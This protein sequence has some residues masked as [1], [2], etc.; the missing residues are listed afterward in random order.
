MFQVLDAEDTVFETKEP[1]S[2][3]ENQTVL[4][5][6]TEPPDKDIV[7]EN[8]ECQLIADKL[9][10]NGSSQDQVEKDN[11]KT[12]GN[13]LSESIPSNKPDSSDSKAVTH[14]EKTKENLQRNVFDAF[15]VQAGQLSKKSVRSGT[16]RV[17]HVV[18]KCSKIK[19]VNSM[20]TNLSP[21]RNQESKN[22]NFLSSF[23]SFLKAQNSSET[24]S[25]SALKEHSPDESKKDAHMIQKPRQIDKKDKIQHKSQSAC[26][27]ENVKK[28]FPKLKELRVSLDSKEVIKHANNALKTNQE[29]LASLKSADK[30]SYVKM[31][32][33]SEKVSTNILPPTNDNVANL[34][35]LAEDSGN[36]KLKSWSK[37]ENLN[38]SKDNTILEAP[39]NAIKNSVV[40]TPVSPYIFDNDS[41]KPLKKRGRRGKRF[42]SFDRVN[43][44]E[45][46]KTEESNLA[47]KTSDAENQ[48][49]KIF[50]SVDIG[51]VKGVVQEV[52]KIDSGTSCSLPTSDLTCTESLQSDSQSS[53]ID[54][55]N[56]IS[57]KLFA[58]KRKG[59]KGKRRKP[60]DVQDSN[61]KQTETNATCQNTD[62]N[63]KEAENKTELATGTCKDV[64]QANKE[65]RSFSKKKSDNL[66]GLKKYPERSCKIHKVVEDERKQRKSVLASSTKTVKKIQNV[67]NLS[68]ASPNHVE[69]LVN[70]SSDVIKPKK[71][72]K[73]KVKPWSWG[74]EKKKYKPKPKVLPIV[75]ALE[76]ISNSDIETN[77]KSGS[78]I[79]AKENTPS[80]SS[81]EVLEM[82]NQNLI[83]AETSDMQEETS[84]SSYSESLGKSVTLTVDI[85]KLSDTCDNTTDLVGQCSLA[86]EENLENDQTNI[87]LI[88]K[89]GHRKQSKHA[90]KN[91]VTMIMKDA[92]IGTKTP[93]YTEECAIKASDDKKDVET[94]INDINYTVDVAN[95]KG[96]DYLQ[97]ETSELVEQEKIECEKEQNL[98]N[99]RKDLGNL[100]DINKSLQNEKESVVKYSLESQ[101]SL[102]VETEK[103]TSEPKSETVTELVKKTAKRGKRVKRGRKG[104]CKGKKAQ[105]VKNTPDL[106]SQCVS[107]QKSSDELV[108][109]LPY[110]TKFPV[111]QDASDS[112]KIVLLSNN[113]VQDLDV[114]QRQLIHNVDQE[115]RIDVAH[116]SPDSGIESVAGSPVGNE[117]PS[118]VLSSEPPS[119]ISYHPI[120]NPS[121]SCSLD[122]EN[123]DNMDNISGLPSSE[124]SA[125]SD[126][127]TKVD[128]VVSPADITVAN[129]N[130]KWSTASI[131][132]ITVTLSA[133]GVQNKFGLKR[134][135][136]EDSN[137]IPMLDKNKQIESNKLKDSLKLKEPT[138][139]SV[140]PS[141]KKNRTNFLLK[142]KTS[143]L[144]QQGRMP[145]EEEKEH[146]L[147][148]KFS[149]LSKI[150]YEK[151]CDNRT[152]MENV[153]ESKVGMNEAEINPDNETCN[154]PELSANNHAEPSTCDSIPFVEQ[155]IES[156]KCAPEMESVKCNLSDCFTKS[157]KTISKSSE[158]LTCL[159]SEQILSDDICRKSMSNYLQVSG[160]HLD[161]I[162]DNEIVSKPSDCLQNQKQIGQNNFTLPFPADFE[163]EKEYQNSNEI[164][165]QVNKDKSEMGTKTFKKR[166][167]PPG[168]HKMIVV[169]KKPGRP[170]GSK[171]KQTLLKKKQMSVIDKPYSSNKFKGKNKKLNRHPGRPKGSCNKPKVIPPIAEIG[172]QVPLTTQNLLNQSSLSLMQWRDSKEQTNLEN[173]ELKKRKRGRPRKNPLPNS[174][175]AYKKTKVRKK[176]PRVKMSEQNVMKVPE[177]SHAIGFPDQEINLPEN[178]LDTQFQRMQRELEKYA[179][180]TADN[181]FLLND[182]LD[183]GLKTSPTIRKSKLHLNVRKNKHRTKDSKSRFRHR[184]SEIDSVT[185]TV[186]HNLILDHQLNSLDIEVS[187][188]LETTK[189]SLITTDGY[190]SF[191]GGPCPPP[192]DRSIDSDTSGGGSSLGAKSSNFQLMME[193]SRYRRKKSKKKLLYFRTKHKNIIDPVFIGE[194]DYLIRE[195]PHLSISSSDETFLKVRPGEVPLPS[196]FKVAI[197][198][199]KKKKKD[200][201]LV[202]EKSR[203]LKHKNVYDSDRLK[204]GRRKGVDENLFDIFGTD[205]DDLNQPHYLPPK[206]RH[207]LFSAEDSEKTGSQNSHKS[208]EKRKVGRPKKVRPPSPTHI[209]SFGK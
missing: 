132:A 203:P 18:K 179:G 104:S 177:E 97:D 19:D 123:C 92:Y 196:I 66:V 181:E 26:L 74:N 90:R 46:H 6:N 69:D 185:D 114:Q 82:E 199:V 28:K 152:N 120:S 172:K 183:T 53:T 3:L 162:S 102:V 35:V 95:K 167:R 12:V 145:T 198:N 21:E 186:D 11:L 75:N 180:M 178:S 65:L 37:H 27:T 189:A 184:S 44:P 153:S 134:S 14:T 129:S 45:S 34:T 63:L 8:V 2:L 168:K 4:L 110:V 76:G 111:D 107:E 52:A 141:K 131:P 24:N 125:L 70:K 147:E 105:H 121:I 156:L 174:S 96:M 39:T 100:N 78:T 202:F 86:P 83:R 126:S 57:A 173:F 103:L 164:N 13:Q 55:S 209:F 127:K 138:T 98:D 150:R 144:L 119:S 41:A 143:V 139:V 201:L 208:Q 113:V 160:E 67:P 207:K 31:S 50:D 124:A 9:N 117:S 64:Q 108:K 68:L 56:P 175:L 151:E 118:S 94:D 51:V 30:C 170:K 190:P 99:V 22:S 29:T 73:R 77:V 115:P 137:D 5:K 87:K 197:I 33:C 59:K 10:D 133:N 148:D 93:E 206:K 130:L 43:E 171:N 60:K 89:H 157:A 79:V 17:G 112:N 136:E 7:S 36:E 146:M 72:R 1:L 71:K 191:V 101:I 106:S 122:S 176:Q 158:D 85:P 204:L 15:P 155:N 205:L 195:F 135:N 61:Q 49:I 47:G 88:K 40:V 23:E 169:K 161:N 140:S 84:I 32:K 80:T 20:K 58:K 38:A 109:D 163:K 159:S 142:H 48:H 91:K 54:I 187:D 192:S 193:Y 128:S 154:E 25:T 81:N 16:N 62:S 200:K 116:V 166:G 149:Y 165:I 42:E 182:M 188:H 194:V